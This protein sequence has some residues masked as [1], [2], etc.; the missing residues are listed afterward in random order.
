MIPLLQKFKRKEASQSENGREVA[1]IA[2]VSGLQVPLSNL[3]QRRMAR[4]NRRAP[5]F[6]AVPPP[7]FAGRSRAA[8]ATSR[9]AG[10]RATSFGPSEFQVTLRDQLTEW[11]EPPEQ[12]LD[13]PP[14]GSPH[15]YDA[16][17]PSRPWPVE[18]PGREQQLRLAAAELVRATDPASPDPDLDLVAQSPVA[19]WDAE[20]ERL[21]GEARAA[22]S[23][24]VVVPLPSSLSA[25]AVARLRSA[26]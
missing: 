16:I 5:N 11:G 6:P 7:R 8:T 25:T 21:V 17:D 9:P 22:R 12:W 15:P 26:T 1:Q 24:E 10:P 2:I 18:G 13:K 4:I 20:I 3:Q 23:E 19:E 14:K